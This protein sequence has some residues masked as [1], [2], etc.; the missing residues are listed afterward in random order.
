MKNPK[1]WTYGGE[2]VST[3][4]SETFPDKTYDIHRLHGQLVCDCGSFRFSRLP[5]SCKHL[6]AYLAGE[7]MDALR[8]VKPTVRQETV[9]VKVKDET[10]TVHRRAISFNRELR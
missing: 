10:F 4:A 8:A 6:E 9:R 2:H 3:V 7:T 5:K 1:D